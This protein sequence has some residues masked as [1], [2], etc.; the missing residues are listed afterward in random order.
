LQCTIFK[1]AEEGNVDMA[2]TCIVDTP[3]CVDTKSPVSNDD[4][5]DDD[6]D[7]GDDDDD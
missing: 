3:S 1:A 4:D 2:K 5:D 7:D 6:D